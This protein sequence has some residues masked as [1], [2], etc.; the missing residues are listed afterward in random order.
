MRDYAE[1]NNDQLRDAIKSMRHNFDTALEGGADGLAMAFEAK[2]ARLWAELV[3]RIQADDPH[4][5]EADI[6]YFEGV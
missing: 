4:T 6:R 3:R 5:T 2:A 1:L